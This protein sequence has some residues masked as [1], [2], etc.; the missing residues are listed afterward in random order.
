MT[1]FFVVEP[2]GLG[3]LSVECMSS[4]LQRI[5][6]AHGVTRHQFLTYLRDWWRKEHHRHLPRCEEL[7]WDG[8][9]KNVE[10]G[11]AALRD[12]FGLDFSSCTLIALK[13][14]CAAN[15]IGSIKHY[16][17][18]CPACFR[19]DLAAQGPTYDRLLWR[20]QGYERC[21]IHKHKLISI[22]PYCSCTQRSDTTRAEL[23]ECSNC[24]QNLALHDTRSTYS[25]APMFGEAQLERLVGDLH[26]IKKTA[27]YPLV[28][29]MS[30]VDIDVNTVTEDLGDLFHTRRCPVKPQLGSLIAV[31]AYFDVDI[32]ELLTNPESAASQ[33]TLGFSRAL[34]SR[35]RR[36]SSLRREERSEWFDSELRKTLEAG[37]PYPSVPEFCKLR[38]FSPRG[39]WYKHGL[40]FD[41]SKKYREWKQSEREKA[42][43]RAVAAIRKLT[44][45]RPTMTTKQFERLVSE[46][47]STPI[48]VV[49]TILR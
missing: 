19:D 2:I 21:S 38:D 49:R 31:S 13:E 4:L 11:L 40:L 28:R 41:L 25:R 7:R 33:A 18:W 37:P 5:A 24:Y 26:V 3:T 44:H 23:H 15:G 10:I 20:I 43:R 6:V 34:P 8:Y 39:A 17:S 27:T 45:L 1:R 22:C 48:H 42:R 14:A 47:A 32:V 9:S 29:F 30:M 16:R 36:P 35:R 12:A 46:R